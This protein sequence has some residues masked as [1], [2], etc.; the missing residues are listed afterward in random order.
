MS[1]T[2]S[3][4]T[5]RRSFDHSSVRYYR[6]PVALGREAA[7]SPAASVSSALKGGM[8]VGHLGVRA[9]SS[10]MNAAA[11]W[12]AAYTADVQAVQAWHRAEAKKRGVQ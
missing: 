3:G 6:C 4:G 11:G 10:G 8:G 2:V 1:E 12:H 7:R 9:L 5:V